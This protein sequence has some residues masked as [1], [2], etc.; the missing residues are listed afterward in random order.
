M[1]SSCPSVSR[2]CTPPRRMGSGGGCLGWLA[3]PDRRSN[4]PQRR[5]YRDVW[6]PQRWPWWVDGLWW[7]VNLEPSGRAGAGFVGG[8]GLG[9]SAIPKPRGR[10]D[11]AGESDIMRGSPRRRVQLDW[12][13]GGAK[14]LCG[15]TGLADC[16]PIART[17]GGS[18]TLKPGVPGPMEDGSTGDQR[19]NFDGGVL[20]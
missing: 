18:P 7:R 8:S 13:R 5:W 3:G 17:S 19:K 4:G 20:N 14:T 1:S 15:S 12:A 16:G 9:G 2:S 6:G 11:R 10:L